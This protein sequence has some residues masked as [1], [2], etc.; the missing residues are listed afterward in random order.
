MCRAREK[1]GTTEGHNEI[2]PPIVSSVEIQRPPSEVFRYATDPERFGEWQKGVVGGYV[3]GKPGLGAHCTM[4]R[5]IVG[6]KRTSSSV[7]TE[8]DPPAH[9]AIHGIDG[10]IRAEVSVVV[11][12]L[13]EARRSRVTIELEFHGHGMG[14]LLAPVITRRARKRVSGSCRHLKERLEAN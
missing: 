9:W 11:E 10:P 5:R 13:D 2:V 3:D 4:T 12:P 8:F 6:T 7:I 1:N 14:R